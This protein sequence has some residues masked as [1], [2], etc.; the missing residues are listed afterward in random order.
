MNKQLKII[1][2]YRFDECLRAGHLINDIKE[3]FGWPVYQFGSRM[4]GIA[5]AS[6]DLDLYIDLGKLSF[7]CVQYHFAHKLL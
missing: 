6:S 5:T 3:I 7:E 2:D 4:T 1:E